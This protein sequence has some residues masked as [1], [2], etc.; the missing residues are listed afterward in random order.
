MNPP[1]FVVNDEAVI[2]RLVGA[3]QDLS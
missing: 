1:V 3:Q 2:I